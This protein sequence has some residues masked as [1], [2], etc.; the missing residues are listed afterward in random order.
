MG[1]V[2][3]VLYDALVKKNSV[4]AVIL[5]GG[6]S[7]RLYPFNKVLS[8]LTG[9]GRSLIEQ[10]ADRLNLLPKKQLYVLTV[11]AMV[12]PIRKQLKWSASHYFVDPVRR[13]TWPALLWAMA[14]LRAKNEDSVLAVVTGD[15]IIPNVKQFQKSFRQG[16]QMARTHPSFV[17]I[18]VKPTSRGEDWVGFGALKT[19]GK[20]LR[21]KDG[22]AC[23]TGFEEKPTVDEAKRRI[24]E[25]G[26]FWN[27]GMFFF[28]IRVAEKV[29]AA[30]QPAMYQTYLKM[31]DAV[32]RGDAKAAAKMF[33]QFPDKIPHPLDASRRVDNTID[34]AIMTPLVHHSDPVALACVCRQALT[35][36]TD[37]GQWSALR[38]VVKPDAHRNLRV[39]R[40]TSDSNT[41]DCILVAGKGCSI[42]VEGLKKFVVASSLE[43]AL[44]VPENDIPRIKE[45]VQ[46]AKANSE[47]CVVE[48]IPRDRVQWRAGH[49]VVS[50][51]RGFIR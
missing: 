34:Y 29:L 19:D 9:S 42:K 21:Q 20:T 4:F 49:L 3:W 7:S 45:I 33:E 13:G 36:W 14:H 22:G 47:R 18:P 26:W 38:Q 2:E 6:Q 10:S 39:G 5:A 12:E 44:V 30:F 50:K 35:G 37:L 43:G 15:H 28:R 40:V 48:G 32:A 27:A 1:G 8:D 25:G 11:R 17:V 41:I 16:V 23:I 24:K 31:A 51:K 46:K